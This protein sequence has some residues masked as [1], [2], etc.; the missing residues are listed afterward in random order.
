MTA[1]KSD[2]VVAARPIGEKGIVNGVRSVRLS[3]THVAAAVVPI[4]VG[5]RISIPSATSRINDGAV[6]GVAGI[7][8]QI[9]C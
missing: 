3:P 6:A 5:G 1:I 4:N 8:S 9:C 2:R 7:P